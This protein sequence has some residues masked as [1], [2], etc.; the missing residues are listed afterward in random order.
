MVSGDGSLDGVVDLERYPLHDMDGPAGRDLI[1]DY[2][3]RLAVDGA[4]VLPGFVAPRALDDVVTEAGGEFQYA[5]DIRSPD[6][7]NYDAVR[8]LVDGDSGDYIT[9]A[10]R[11]AISVFSRAATTCTG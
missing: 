11:T 8:R 3:A 10:R 2:A 4:C 1:A 6:N 9:L 7:E 5:P